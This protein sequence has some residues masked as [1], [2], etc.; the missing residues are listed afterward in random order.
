MLGFDPKILCHGVGR[1][2]FVCEYASN[3]RKILSGQNKRVK[4]NALQTVREIS[5]LAIARWVVPRSKRSPEYKLWKNEDV[6]INMVVSD[7]RKYKSKTIIN[8]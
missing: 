2:V 4:L 3:V 8:S 7:S 5:N 1:E 6:L